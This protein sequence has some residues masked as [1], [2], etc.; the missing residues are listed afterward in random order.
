MGPGTLERM[1]PPGMKVVLRIYGFIF[2]EK[3]V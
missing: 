1:G 3:T 2:N